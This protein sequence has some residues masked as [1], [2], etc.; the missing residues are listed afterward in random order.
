MMLDPILD[1][2]RRRVETLDA[3]ALE[4]A[5]RSQP[6]ARDFLAALRRPGLQVIAE[7]KRRSPSAG[8][9]AAELDPAARAH[10]YAAGGAAAISVLT[11]PNFFGGSVADLQTVRASVDIPVLRKDF[12]LS[13]AQIWEAR[14]AGADAVLLIVAALSPAAL[15]ELLATAREAGL[16]ALVE[17]HTPEEAA[18]A[19]KA[20][21]ELVGVN[22]RDL[23]TF[24]TDLR[25]AEDVARH[26]PDGDVRVAESGVA[27]PEGATRMWTAGYDAILVGEALVRA[28]DPAALVA[29][30]RVGP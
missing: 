16:A 29:Q 22:N 12:T 26:L 14:A 9:I 7:I 13:P 17:V 15:D 24:R 5:A 4:A 2:T 27:T 28:T 10:A 25:V 1:A 11:E 20:G 19:A 18:V 6:P 8:V 21:A 3:V 30:L 23:T